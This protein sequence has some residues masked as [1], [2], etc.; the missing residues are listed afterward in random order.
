MFSLAAVLFA[1][2]D[3]FLADLKLKGRSPH[4]LR[5]YE[6]DVIDFLTL[7]KHIGVGTANQIEVLQLRRYVQHRRDGAGRD[8]ERSVGRRLSAVRTYLSYLQRHGVIDG[9]P[10]LALRAPK[11]RRKLPKVFSQVEVG[12]LLVAP[13][14]EGYLGRR[15]RAILEVLYSGGLRVSELTGLALGDL[16]EDGILRVLGK[17][18]KERLGVLGKPAQRAVSA[19]REERRKLLKR[20]HRDGQALFLNY[21]GTPLTPR[22]VG[23][24]VERYCREAGLATRGSPHTLRHSFATHLLEQGA[25]LRSV[26]E[27]LGHEQVT[28]TQIYTHLSGSRLREIYDR[29]HPRAGRN[30]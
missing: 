27:L 1:Y 11:Q 3:E 18:S 23:R 19:Y 9:N 2:L 4:T 8:S 22:S 14:A 6:R 16:R 17:R 30:G 13:K 20:V 21:R 7:M 28:T 5:A 24:M 15:D 29:A 25:D 10:A 26:Q 12:R